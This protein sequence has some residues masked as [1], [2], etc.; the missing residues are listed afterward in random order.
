M[1]I[2][3]K[4]IRGEFEEMQWFNGCP[5][6]HSADVYETLATVDDR[7]NVE[8]S[9]CDECGHVEEKWVL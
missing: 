6:C 7:E 1:S 8:V 9:I 2:F 4:G 3:Q 5:K